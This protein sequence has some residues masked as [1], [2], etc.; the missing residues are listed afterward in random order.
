MAPEQAKG[1]MVDRRADMWAFGCVLVPLDVRG[2]SDVWLLDVARGSSTRFTSTDQPDDEQS[3]CSQGHYDREAHIA[4]W[5]FTR[6]PGDCPRD[7][8][9][10]SAGEDN[11]H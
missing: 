2:L 8:K 10:E 3:R 11:D 4:K 5:G 6:R 1:K 7:D 9:T